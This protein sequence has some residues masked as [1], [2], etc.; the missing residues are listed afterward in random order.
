MNFF[1]IFYRNLASNDISFLSD[2]MFAQLKNLHSLYVKRIAT[3]HLKS[4]VQSFVLNER[5]NGVKPSAVKRPKCNRQ[6]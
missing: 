1:F 4:L 6:P 2:E 3:I 5:L